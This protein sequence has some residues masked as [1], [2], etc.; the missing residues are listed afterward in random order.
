MLLLLHPAQVLRKNKEI[1]QSCI[2]DLCVFSQLAFKSDDKGVAITKA[3]WLVLYPLSKVHGFDV[4][5]SIFAHDWHGIQ[6]CH[7]AL[8]SCQDKGSTFIDNIH[9]CEP[10]WPLALA[11]SKRVCHKDEYLINKMLAA[12]VPTC[13]CLVL[14]AD[15]PTKGM[16]FRAQIVSKLKDSRYR[17]V[18]LTAALHDPAGV[19]KANLHTCHVINVLKLEMLHAELWKLAACADIPDNWK[20]KPHDGQVW[21]PWLAESLRLLLP[22]CSGVQPL[23]LFGERLQ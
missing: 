12:L 5:V 11:A 18:E 10:D 9:Q 23:V 16:Y 15:Q 4:L 3:P 1:A 19:E 2:E 20:E 21:S 7:P 13:S 14:E 22:G 17:E 6:P 8:P